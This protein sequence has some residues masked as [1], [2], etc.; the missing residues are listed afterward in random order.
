VIALGLGA[1]IFF[2]E[3][4]LRPPPTTPKPV[5]PG[6][7]ARNVTN[8]SIL[9]ISA[10]EIR[11]EATNG[12]WQILRPLDYP[13]RSAAPN[14]LLAALEKLMPDA[15]ISGREVRE[16]PTGA[17]A[18]GLEPAQ[19]TLTLLADGTRHQLLF[20]SRTAPGDQVFLQVVGSEGVYVVG[21]DILKFLPTSAN[22]WR[23]P[24]LISLRSLALN[25][26]TVTNGSTV[27]ELQLVSTNQTWRM[28]RPRAQR[29]NSERMA[30][31]IAN[32]VKLR[33]SQFVTDD[34]AADREG[35]GLQPPALSVGFF[36][37]TNLTTMLHFGKSPTNDAKLVYARRQGFP[38]VTTVD[39]ELT[40][41][42]LAPVNDYRD[43]RLLELDTPPDYIEL[44]G[45]ES[46]A[47]QRQADGNWR[48]PGQS[49]PVDAAAAGEI[50][51]TVTNLMITNFA[52]DVVIGPDLPKFGLAAP[53]RE[54]R[55]YQ[56]PMP[57]GNGTNLL[58]A[59]LAF[60][61]QRDGNIFVRRADEDSIY[62]VPAIGLTP[63]P[64]AA[65]Q[66][67]SRRLWS[68]SESNVAQV[69]IR[70][71]ALS[72]TLVRSGTNSW[73]LA[74][75]SQGEILSDAV[76]ETV[77]RLGELSAL[78]WVARGE[79][80]LP[81]LRFDTNSIALTVELKNGTKHAVSFGGPSPS[82]YPCAAVNFDGEPWICDI[83][84]GLHYL[85][86]THLGLAEAKR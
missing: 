6:F 44:N 54:I 64:T 35:L 16:R 23:D 80:N 43:R 72:R 53:V 15:V 77:H 7:N 56:T 86:R 79:T 19:I 8:L 82:G 20:G 14:A 84:I 25:R 34:P 28:T 66:L 74:P 2:V 31:L 46:F 17:A 1:F 71:G 42:W 4:Q 75:G 65:F 61:S 26:I 49:M 73:S 59:S 36:L 76:E 47:L 57:A 33:A 48:V 45:Q 37:G 55:F 50:L 78:A 39:K 67:R 12:A 13:A 24:A 10:D 60:G 22:A 9:P 81:S 11:V 21:A 51:A 83:P 32:L 38:T 63:L 5:L 41:G 29:V 70:Q 62:E 68:F 27:I 18:F 40:A 85:I 3:P 52:Q 69:T 30:D 58:L